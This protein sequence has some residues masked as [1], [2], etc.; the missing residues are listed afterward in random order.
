MIASQTYV[1]QHVFLESR[2][3]LKKVTHARKF[4]S[5]KNGLKWPEMHFKHNFFL[6][7]SWE[8]V[9]LTPSPPPVLGKFP[10]SFLESFPNS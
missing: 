4:K 7:K 9:S 1:L 3:H 10:T 2:G 5:E 8:H 6:N